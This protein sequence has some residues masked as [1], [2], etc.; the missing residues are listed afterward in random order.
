MLSFKNYAN[1]NS[2]RSFTEWPIGALN[3]ESFSFLVP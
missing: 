2:N 3:E 1:R